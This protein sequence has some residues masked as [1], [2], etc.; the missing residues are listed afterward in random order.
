MEQVLFTV[1]ENVRL[2]AEVCRMVLEGDTRAIT[3]PGQF[4]DLRVPGFTLR[5]PISVC[6]WDG[7]TVTIVYKV[8]GAG[9]AELERMSPG[10]RL[11]ALVG[12]GNGFD[13]ARSGRRPLLVG[14]GVGTPPLYALC[15]A[16]WE[17][18]KKP[19]VVLGFRTAGEILLSEEFAALGAEV[20]ITTEDGSAG[21]KGFVTAVMPELDY[22][23][24]YACGPIP[25]LRAVDGAAKTGGQLSFEERMGCGFGVC[26]GCSWMT[27]NGSKRI[28]ADGPVLEREELIWDAQQ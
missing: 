5:R 7:E 11:D 28:C 6:D 1:R 13:T 2:T 9:T 10:E 3:A 27:K 25:M 20:H 21:R 17:E 24:L 23:Y 4:I 15:R 16:L 18:G 12:L 14:G 26:M 8:V 19:V 22:T